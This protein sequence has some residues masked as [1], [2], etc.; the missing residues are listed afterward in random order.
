M[1]REHFSARA[2][3]G[4]LIAPILIAVL[5]L[6]L[7]LSLSFLKVYGVTIPAVF[8]IALYSSVLYLAWLYRPVRY[9]DTAVLE[10]INILGA[11]SEVS[12]C[13]KTISKNRLINVNI[14]RFLG[15]TSRKPNQSEIVKHVND[16]GINLTSTR[17]R[18]IAGDLEKIGLVASLRGTHE[19]EYTLTKKGQWCFLAVE[20][21]FPKRNGLFVLRNEILQKALQP[22]P[23]TNE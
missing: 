7:V 21:Y 18:E 9:S 20:Y 14:I 15:R 8:I 1:K 16:S 12:D 17:I 23:E 10:K 3:F 22:F 4:L 11:P 19:R 6:L 5:T 13:L 2:I